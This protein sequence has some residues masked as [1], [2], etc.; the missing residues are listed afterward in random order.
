[1]VLWPFGKTIVPKQRLAAKDAC[2]FCVIRLSGL[3]AVVF[4]T[5]IIHLLFAAFL[6]ITIIYILFKPQHLKLMELS[7]L[8]L[9]ARNVFR[10]NGMLIH[11]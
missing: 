2:R 6:S 9:L 8:G 1:M 10:L 5:A 3:F 7:L 11:F 4:I